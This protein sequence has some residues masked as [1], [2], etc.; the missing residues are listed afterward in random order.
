MFDKNY[1]IDSILDSV[2][3]KVKREWIDDPE[4]MSGILLDPSFEGAII[5]SY[6]V[7]NVRRR[8]SYVFR[9][10][11][12]LRLPISPTAVSRK[13]I[14]NTLAFDNRKCYPKE[15][16]NQ[17]IPLC[18]HPL[19]AYPYEGDLVYLDLKKAFFQLYTKMPVYI[20]YRRNKWTVS[21]P[22]L[23]P[24]LPSD[25]YDYKLIRNSLVGCWRSNSVARIKNGGLK[26]DKTNVPTSNFWAWNF[27]QS[28]L[29]YFAQIALE[30]GAVYVHTDGYIFPEHSGHIDFLQYMEEL[31]FF[32]A[33]KARGY[34]RVY[35][36]GRYE[37]GSYCT[38]V[39]GTLPTVKNIDTSTDIVVTLLQLKKH[40]P[41]WEVSR[42]YVH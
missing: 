39:I 13:I 11:T 36:V 3:A 14:E 42:K 24:R 37:I 20:G 9:D 23:F 6:S 4:F 8:T 33:V 19:Y 26:R 10:F 12:S 32:L 30:S 28:C 34:G 21:P 15:C 18:S 41:F 2:E 25:L 29:N 40:N 7:Y 27:I 22:W 38:K 35:G 1:T 17:E 16:R 31:G 5:G